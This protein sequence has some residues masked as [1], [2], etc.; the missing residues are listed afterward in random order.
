[1]DLA[2][3]MQEANFRFKSMFALTTALANDLLILLRSSAMGANP[4]LF[5]TGSLPFK[6]CSPFA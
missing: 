2:E 5:L 1:M 6:L 4:F 3:H